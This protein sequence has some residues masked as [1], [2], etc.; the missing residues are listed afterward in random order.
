MTI[1][2]AID[3]IS[4]IVRSFELKSSLSGFLAF[5]KISRVDYLALVPDLS[6]LAVLDIMYPVSII[7]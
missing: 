4:F 7:E 3:K 1:K 5:N 2:F 6:T